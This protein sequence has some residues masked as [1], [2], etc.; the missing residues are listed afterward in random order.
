MFTKRQHE[1]RIRFLEVSIRWHRVPPPPHHRIN[2]VD[3][4]ET[5]TRV[6]D[7]IS[8]SSYPLA[9]GGPSPHHR[10][11]EVDAYKTATRP[12]ASHFSLNAPHHFL[13][14][15]YSKK[16]RSESGPMKP[17]LSL[18][19]VPVH[20]YALPVSCEHDQCPCLCNCATSDATMQTPTCVPTSMLNY[21]I[22]FDYLSLLVIHY[23]TLIVICVF[24]MII[25]HRC[26]L[27]ISECVLYLLL[28]LL[29]M[30]YFGLTNISSCS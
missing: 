12:L 17:S 9:S 13:Q 15:T 22:V 18:V 6:Q 14:M 1:S 28:L 25:A 26:L 8:R 5:T 10:I 27:I 30:Q 7:T 16:W 21:H 24:L 29:I 3:V 23:H 20:F 4:H 11:N 19:P 2:E